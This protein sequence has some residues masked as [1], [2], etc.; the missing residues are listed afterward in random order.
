MGVVTGRSNVNHQ[1]SFFTEIWLAYMVIS[2][3]RRKGKT[4]SLFKC[5]LC[6][7]TWSET[8]KAFKNN[9]KNRTTFKIHL[10]SIHRQQLKYFMIFFSQSNEVLFLNTRVICNCNTEINL[11]RWAYFFLWGTNEI[12]DNL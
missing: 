1:L 7:S 10:L 9:S 5:S 2:T 11:T 3:D 6:F 4:Q 8:M 12:S